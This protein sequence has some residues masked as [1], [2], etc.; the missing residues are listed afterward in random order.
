MTEIREQ[1]A[2][3]LIEGGDVLKTEKGTLWGHAL[4]GKKKEGKRRA[5]N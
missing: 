1:S 2:T 3:S 5:A 4:F